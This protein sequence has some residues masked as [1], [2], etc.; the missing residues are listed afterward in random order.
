MIQLENKKLVEILKMRDVEIKN[1]QK[2]MKELHMVEIKI[3]RLE[4]KEKVITG[5]TVPPKELTDRGEKLIGQMKELD[6][7]IVKITEEITKMKLDAVPKD[8]KE[9]HEALMKEREQLERDRNKVALKIQK[10]RDKYIP[11]IRKEVKPLLKDYEDIETVRLKGDS[12]VIPVIDRL[13]EFKR[14][15]RR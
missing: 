12:V 11:L 7:E 2:I 3:K 6:A 10:Y 4:E 14:H 5:K 8:I 9:A 13:E 15:F 1:V